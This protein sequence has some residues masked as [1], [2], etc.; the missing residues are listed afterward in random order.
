MNLYKLLTQISLIVKPHKPRNLVK[1]KVLPKAKEVHRA[2]L[3]AYNYRI[4]V[5]ILL[6]TVSGCSLLQT[7]PRPI[8]VKTIAEM[9][10]I[11]D[12]PLPLELQLVDID[13]TIFTPELMQ[14][15]LDQVEKGDA[16]RQAFY[17]L[18][19][20]EYENLSMN[21]ADQKRYLKEIIG[22]VKYYREIDEPKKV[23]EPK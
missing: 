23:S 12:P 6:F 1:P 3:S 7:A 5:I 9:P 18:T 11:Y 22:I 14:N 2:Y 19:T 15:Y 16:P 20:K 10:N 4:F 13:W 8:A 21:T 17:A